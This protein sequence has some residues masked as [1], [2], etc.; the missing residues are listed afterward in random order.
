MD[1]LNVDKDYKEAFNQ[2]YELAQELGLQPD[3]LKNLKS[4]NNRMQAM[5]E[6]MEQYQTEI[7]QTKNLK[8]FDLDSFEGGY[9]DLDSKEPS[10]DK[11]T[12]LEK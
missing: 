11:G 5:R 1:E 9:I 12:D 2:G 3:V 8:S 6:G 10:K 4:G 7:D